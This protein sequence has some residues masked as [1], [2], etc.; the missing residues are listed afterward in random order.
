M[1]DKSLIIT[2]TIKI[3]ENICLHN[4]VS[5]ISKKLNFVLVSFFKFFIFM[6]IL[7]NVGT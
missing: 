3:F 1:N 5:N 4:T 6:Y 2:I 7:K